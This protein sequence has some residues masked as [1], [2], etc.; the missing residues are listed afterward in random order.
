MFKETIAQVKLK[1]TRLKLTLTTRI[2]VFRTV[3]YRLLSRT[4]KTAVFVKT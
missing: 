4:K 2:N 3:T 1:V